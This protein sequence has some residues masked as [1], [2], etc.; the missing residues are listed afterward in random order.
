MSFDE[1]FDLTAGVYYNFYDIYIYIYC[2]KVYLEHRVLD[3]RDA[4]SSLP[5]SSSYILVDMH[6]VP[7]IH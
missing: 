1:I 6:Y 3:L 7:W 5:S 2:S 4:V